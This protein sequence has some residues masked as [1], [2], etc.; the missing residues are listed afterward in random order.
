VVPDTVQTP[1]VV[2]DQ[3]TV[4]PEVAVAVELEILAVV[5]VQLRFAKSDAVIVWLAC[6]MTKL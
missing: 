1:V 5:G 6:E 4:S 3:E 2:D